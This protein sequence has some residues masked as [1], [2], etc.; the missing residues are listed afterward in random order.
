MMRSPASKVR[1]VPRAVSAA[2]SSGSNPEQRLLASGLTTN[3]E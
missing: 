1:H 3:V 2:I